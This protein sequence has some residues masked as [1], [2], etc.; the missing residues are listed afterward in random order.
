MTTKQ[1]ASANGKDKTQ[2]PVT[3]M[4]P[5]PVTEAIEVFEYGDDAGQ[6]F[7]NQDMSDRKLPIIELLQSNSP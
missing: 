5:P 3:A 2:P 1:Q 7:E 6:G 4:T